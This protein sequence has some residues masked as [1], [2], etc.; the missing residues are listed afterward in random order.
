MEFSGQ[1]LTYEEYKGLGGTLSQMSFNILEFEA[2]KTI[3]KY[4]FGRLK[5]L[6][7]QIQ[8]VKLC[9]YDLIKLNEC[10]DVQINNPKSKGV[11]SESTDGYSISY[12]DTTKETIETRNNETL[13]IISNYLSDCQLDD[14]TPYLYRGA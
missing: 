10:Y 9:V 12:K 2:R 4:T 6:E 8:E 3:D 13:D 5:Q 11:A 1:Y 7:N 14:G